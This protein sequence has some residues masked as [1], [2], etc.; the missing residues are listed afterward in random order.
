[1]TRRDKDGDGSEGGSKSKGE[2]RHKGPPRGPAALKQLIKFLMPLAGKRIVVMLLLAVARTALSNRLARVQVWEKPP[3]LLLFPSTSP[4][5]AL[6]LC[7]SVKYASNH[8]RYKQPH[9]I[10]LLVK[11]GPT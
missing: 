1:M 11:N 2:R 4:S 6:N 5:Y 10:D 7:M 3:S 9:F 8:N